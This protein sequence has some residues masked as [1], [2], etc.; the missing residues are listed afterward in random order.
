MQFETMEAINGGEIIQKGVIQHLGSYYIMAD[1]GTLVLEDDI[2]IGL[3]TIINCNHYI[4][5]GKCVLIAEYCSI[6]DSGHGYKDSSK[7]I[8]HQDDEVAPIYIEDGVWIAAGCRILKGVRIGEGAIVGANSVVTKD[9]APYTIVG[10][11][12]A[13]FIKSRFEGID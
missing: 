12:P 11:N 1:K 2:F 10:G 7:Y 8:K 3:G 6:R 13:K 9:V 4:H 5:I